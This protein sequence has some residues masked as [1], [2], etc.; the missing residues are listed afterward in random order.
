MFNTLQSTEIETQNLK[1]NMK[2]KFEEFLK[3]Y[4]LIVLGYAGFDNSV[5]D[6]LIDL[7]SQADYLNNG[8]YWCI[9]KEEF[10]N[11][12]LSPKLRELLSKDKVYYI[13]IDNF[14][15]FSAKLAHLVIEKDIIP[16]G[17]THLSRLENRQ[18]FFIK[19]KDL[20]VNDPLITNDV[21]DC[22]ASP[23]FSDQNNYDFDDNFKSSKEKNG[24]MPIQ[25]N[26]SNLQK[27]LEDTHIYELMWN[28]NY[29]EAL[30][31]IDKKI[32]NNIPSYKYNKYMN[33][34]VKCYLK[35]KQ[36]EKAL[37][38]INQVL[39]YNKRNK[40]DSNIPIL[41]EKANIISS[42]PEKIQIIELALQQDCNNIDII[43]FLAEAKTQLIKHNPN[44]YQNVID[45]YD[46]SIS[47]QASSNNE[48]YLEKLNFVKKYSNE[49]KKEKILNTCKQIIQDI[50]N[51]D[52]YSLCVYDAKME[53]LY[54]EEKDKQNNDDI[55]ITKMRDL[56]NEYIGGNC[57]YERN[58]LYLREYLN[59]LSKLSQ[60]EELQDMFYKYDN[61][62]KYNVEYF[63][64]KADIIL[65]K[66]KNLDG[67]ITILENI[68]KS[69]IRMQSKLRSR[70]YNQY[71]EYLL[72]NSEYNKICKI[73]DNEPDSK[74][75]S[76]FNAYKEALYYIDQN[77][78]FEIIYKD[79][80]NSEKSTDDY[81]AYTYSL[82]KLEM[83]QEIY[84]I[85]KEL[86]ANQQKNINVDV[87]NDILRINYNLAK[88]HLNKTI[89]KSNLEYIFSQ[90]SDSVEKAAAYILIDKQEEAKKILSTEINDDY[91]Y[92]YSL[93]VMPAFQSINFENLKLQQVQVNN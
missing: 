5:M 64:Q 18:K 35:L 1:E 28:K 20:F 56:F 41:L 59:L 58:E 53:Q 23:P 7:V 81:I 42:I 91:Q 61:E 86:F 76:R 88:K 63:L 37:D 21:N 71:F 30:A 67:A 4:G 11:D 34:K 57:I 49:N 39:N 60:Y 72:Y 65:S 80:E 24:F 17:S 52:Y 2:I 33:M 12:N 45:L 26:E 87:N 83:Y 75:L 25:T 44:L 3:N 84:D 47:L 62:N 8:I 6:V 79:F 32:T 38:I 14:D 10:E 93:Q 15:S 92:Y 89:T 90:K 36:K 82:L 46:R 40:K 27:T 85:C 43:N 78:Y 55:N 77:R 66:F 19:Q 9:K 13:L 68:D 74:I 54:Q 50:E 70:Y 51:K 29:N 16:L 69:L 73:V 22:L 31:I 48:A